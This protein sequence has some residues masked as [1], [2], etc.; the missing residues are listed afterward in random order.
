MQ[1]LSTQALLPRA[2]WFL[3]VIK[4]MPSIAEL[5]FAQSRTRFK[6]LAN[7]QR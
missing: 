6:W 4:A 2:M 5:D 7:I 1:L 3:S